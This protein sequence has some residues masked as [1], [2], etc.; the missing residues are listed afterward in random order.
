MLQ[1]SRNNLIFVPSFVNEVALSL[2]AMGDR[3]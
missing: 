3:H 2:S 1:L